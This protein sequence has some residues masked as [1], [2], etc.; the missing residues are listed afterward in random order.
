[1]EVFERRSLYGGA[2]EMEVPKR[3]L[4]VSAIRETPDNQE[5]LVDADSDQSV[6]VELL[7]QA[8]EAP[9]DQIAKWHFNQLAED[10]AAQNP[11]VLKVSAIEPH[12]IPRFITQECPV[13][14]QVLLGQQFVSKYKEQAPNLISIVLVVLRVASISTDILITFNGP[15]YISPQS[16]SSTQAQA[17]VLSVDPQF[18]EAIVARIL[19]TLRVNDWSL[20]DE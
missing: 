6:I 11:Q 1:M 3:F 4:D 14:G 13:V 18:G 20:F 2:I 7:A 12:Q 15:T 19:Q 9:D 16:S 5:V 17:H 10:N 8:E